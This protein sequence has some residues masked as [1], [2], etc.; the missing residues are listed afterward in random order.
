M[1]KGRY[2]N[3]IW[4]EDVDLHTRVGAII[5]DLSADSEG[6]SLAFLAQLRK[7]GPE[8]LIASF[9]IYRSADQIARRHLSWTEYVL[10]RPIIVGTFLVVICAL[11]KL[12]A[13][14]ILGVGASIGYIGFS[15]SSWNTAAVDLRASQAAARH[16]MRQ[17]AR[18]IKWLDAPWAVPT[19]LEFM[20]LDRPTA[21]IASGM[22]V[23]RLPET[24]KLS[25][26]QVSAL[27][28]CINQLHA[29]FEPDLVVAALQYLER[30]AETSAIL[31]VRNLVK[32]IKG[33][34][35]L[36]VVALWA[37]RCLES[38]EEVKRRRAE[39]ST[40]LRA[41]TG[42]AESEELLRPISPQSIHDKSKLVR[43]VMPCAAES[44]EADGDAL[45]SRDNTRPS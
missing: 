32:A 27:R 23:R 33:D 2:V 11:F 43:I 31:P 21:L 37:E 13:V 12:P 25:A 44:L 3:S 22:I 41:A 28:D 40:L 5:D 39:E 14:T 1:Q 4:L 8:G 45:D 24:Q 18:Y 15:V 36:C 38:L 20:H 42:R 10:F 6:R 30:T 26:L 35:A 16:R 19:T 29:Q 7:L 17:I 9:A 34:A